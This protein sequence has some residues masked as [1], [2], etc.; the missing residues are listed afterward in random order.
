M[1]L[2]DYNSALED[3]NLSLLNNPFEA[4]SYKFRANAKDKLGD[5]TGPDLDYSIYKEI[6]S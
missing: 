4:I 3:F 5:K 2:N 6:R 1:A